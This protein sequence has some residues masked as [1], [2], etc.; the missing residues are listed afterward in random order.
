MAKKGTR[1]IKQIQ[2]K[3]NKACTFYKRKKVLIKK[4]MEISI[5]CGV[6]VGLYMHD[7]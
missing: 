1:P 6:E 7:K 2:D 5:L 3:K 4:A